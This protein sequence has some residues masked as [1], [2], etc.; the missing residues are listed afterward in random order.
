MCFCCTRVVAT[1]AIICICCV[2][3]ANGELDARMLSALRW[4]NWKLSWQS[5]GKT[6]FGRNGLGGNLPI[7]IMWV[8]AHGFPQQNRN[9]G[10]MPTDG[11]VKIWSIRAQVKFCQVVKFTKWHILW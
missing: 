2:C 11:H 10:H 4:R 9:E 1:F 6:S 5:P 3:H 7:D 8:L